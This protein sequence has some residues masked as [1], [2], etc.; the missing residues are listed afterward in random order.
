MIKAHPFMPGSWQTP[1][2]LKWLRRTHAWLGLAGAVAGVL[3]SITTLF[4]EY[5][6]FGLNG[7]VVPSEVTEFA[8]P[9]SALASYDDFRTYA[10][11]QVGARRSGGPPRNFTPTDDPL[12]YQVRFNSPGDAIDVRFQAGDLVAQATRT[13]RSFIDT[14]NRLHRAEGGPIGWRILSDAYTGALVVL[15][16]TGVLMWS[17]LHGRR[18]LGVG[19]FT[20]MFVFALYFMTLTP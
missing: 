12:N 7:E 1:T 5:D 2:F 20:G 19:L 14:L 4:M 18:L 10:R 11:E 17:R 9:A 16:I 13:N 15:A 3:F 6:D 8:V